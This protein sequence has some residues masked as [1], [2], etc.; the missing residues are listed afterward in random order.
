MISILTRD[1]VLWILVISTLL[2]GCIVPKES[3]RDKR[4]IK[5]K[6]SAERLLT[7]YYTNE[8]LAYLHLHLYA[9]HTF[10]I[11]TTGFYSAYY[12]A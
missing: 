4:Y 12:Y 3:R 1:T 7:A 6:A 11:R 9:D 8:A 2:T 10:S 5:K